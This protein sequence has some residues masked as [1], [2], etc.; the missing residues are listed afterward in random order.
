VEGSALS[1]RIAKQLDHGEN[2]YGMVSVYF[3]LDEI[4]DL[5]KKLDVDPIQLEAV[6]EVMSSNAQQ[7]RERM[8]LDALV[9]VQNTDHADARPNFIIHKSDGMFDIYWPG[10]DHWEHNFLTY[11]EAFCHGASEG[12]QLGED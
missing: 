11:G 12:G 5:M 3:N 7:Y 9:T 4:M 6:I 8:I 2:V 1:G 10:T